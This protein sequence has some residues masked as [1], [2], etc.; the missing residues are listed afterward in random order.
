MKIIIKNTLVS[1][2]YLIIHDSELLMNYDHAIT[3]ENQ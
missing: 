3:H 1:V 2:R